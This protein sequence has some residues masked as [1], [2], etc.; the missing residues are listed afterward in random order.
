MVFI[1]NSLDPDLGFILTSF[2]WIQSFTFLNKIY[3]VELFTENGAGF[4][5][6]QNNFNG[7]DFLLL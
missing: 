5:M 2:S 7:T 1:S 4:K 6:A 3:F